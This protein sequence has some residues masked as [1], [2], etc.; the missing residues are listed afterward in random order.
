MN[1]RTPDVAKRRIEIFDM[2]VN[3]SSYTDIGRAFGITRQRVQQIVRPPRLV[4]DLVRDRANNTCQGC[5]I[6]LRPGDG[7]VHHVGQAARTPDDFNDPDNLEYLCR[8]CHRTRH[9]T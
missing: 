4:H 1:P 5:G 7:H 6:Q 3:G 8:S 2:W 9:Q